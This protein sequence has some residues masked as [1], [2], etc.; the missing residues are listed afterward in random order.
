MSYEVFRTGVSDRDLARP[1]AFSRLPPASSNVDARLLAQ[2]AYPSDRSVADRSD[3][4]AHPH[5]GPVVAVVAETPK[6]QIR[7]D[8]KMS[9][10]IHT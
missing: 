5:D 8:R 4:P 1:E 7:R 6:C 9:F 3:H 2:S 10:S